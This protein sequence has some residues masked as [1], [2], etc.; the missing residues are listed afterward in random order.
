LEFDVNDIFFLLIFRVVDY[1]FKVAT[2]D[3]E[4]KLEQK[5]VCSALFYT[6]LERLLF[7]SLLFV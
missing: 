7:A 2:T 5:F 4:V 6:K 3:F 1:L